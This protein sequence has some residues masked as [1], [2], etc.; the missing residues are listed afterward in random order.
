MLFRLLKCDMNNTNTRWL[1]PWQRE[2][3]GGTQDSHYKHPMHSV[4]AVVAAAQVLLLPMAGNTT[5]G[6]GRRVSVAA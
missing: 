2:T 1:L 3:S 6:A 4:V 5:H